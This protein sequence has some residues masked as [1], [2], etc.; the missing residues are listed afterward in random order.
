MKFALIA[1]LA[2]S[3]STAAMAQ[4]SSPDGSEPAFSI[5][6]YV[7]VLGGY[8][9]FDRR[10]EFGTVG[11]RGKM[12]GALIEGVAGV[13]MPFGPVFVGVEGNAAKGFK[14]IDWEYGVKGRFGVR[15]GQS[16]LIFASAGYQWVNGRRGFSDQKGWSYGI[17]TE[18][19]PKDIGLGGVF[20]EAGPRLRF[21]ADTYDFDSIRPMAGLVFAF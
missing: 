6:P 2:A 11:P 13:N 17:G 16:G 1:V 20:G 18:I 19:G 15:A 3:I 14:D 8:H 10:S 12:D 7:G 4:D 9:N 21:Q 5:E